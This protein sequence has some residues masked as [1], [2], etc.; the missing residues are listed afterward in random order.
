M[1]RLGVLGSTRG[2]N[3]QALIDAIAA[4]QLQASIEMIVSNKRDAYILERAALHQLPHQFVD[5]KDL[6]REEYDARVAKLFLSHQIDLVVLIGYMRILS[7]NFISHW[8]NKIIN[9]HPSLLP[10]HAGLMDLDVHRAVI[11]ANEKQSGCSVH[12]VT[13]TV[14]AGPVLLQ[15]SCEVL[16]DDTPE[17]LKVRVQELEAVA[18][19]E[20]IRL[21]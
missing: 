21:L 6:T 1:I 15:K 12:I 11:N 3:L 8:Q 4:K 5:P 20:A 13:E 14:D 18:L 17:S 10:A 2:T 19:I 16:E 9:V 7:A